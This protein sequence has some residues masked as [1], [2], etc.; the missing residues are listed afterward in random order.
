MAKAVNADLKSPVTTKTPKNQGSSEPRI[1]KPFSWPTRRVNT[2]A[3]WAGCVCRLV[4]VPTSPTTSPLGFKGSY[5]VDVARPR[6][7]IGQAERREGA[8]GRASGRRPRG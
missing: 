2:A 4:C 1:E 3:G 7:A 8:S 5:F 6:Q